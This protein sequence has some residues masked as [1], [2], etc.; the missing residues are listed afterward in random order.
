MNPCVAY[1]GTKFIIEWYFDSMG[2]SQSLE[3]FNNQPKDRQRKIVNLFRLMGEHGT[4][5]DKTKLRNE[6]DGIYALKPQ[7]DRHLCFFFKGIKII[8]TNGYLKKTHRFLSHEKELALE[9]YANYEE[10][11]KAYEEKTRSTYE[12]LIENKLQKRLLDREY[13]ELLLSELLLGVMEEEHSSVQQL[14]AEADVSATIIHSMRSGKKTDITIDT[15]S[16]ILDVVG[17]EIILAPKSGS[18]KCL[19]MA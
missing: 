14:A 13:R 7:P 3:Y 12:T 11:A 10:S 8:V 16:R 19:K 17:Y 5:F 1:E 6:G 2:R 15:L 9:A 4:I 18:R